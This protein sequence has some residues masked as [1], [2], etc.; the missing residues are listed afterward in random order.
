MIQRTIDILNKAKTYY[1]ADSY[2][3]DGWGLKKKVSDNYQLGF[4]PI[5]YSQLFRS[6]LFEKFDSD[7]IP[8]KFMDGEYTYL[9]TK[10]FT[11][12]LSAWHR[13]LLGYDDEDYLPIVMQ[14]ARYIEHS[15]DIGPKGAVFRNYEV[16]TGQH[17]GRVC[18]AMEQGLGI[19]IL[20]IAGEIEKDP[21]YAILAEKCLGPYFRKIEDGGVARS[22]PKYDI[23][24]WYEE[25]PTCSAHVL[26]GKLD[27]ILGPAFLHQL[28][29]SSTA[30]E[31][32]DKGLY[33]VEK[34]LP[35]FDRKYWSNYFI[36]DQGQAYIASMKYHSIHIF[37]LRALATL[38]DSAL[39]EQYAALFQRYANSRRNRLKALTV[40]ASQKVRKLHRR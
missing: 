25:F 39:C 13:Y 11:Y 14:I 2:V 24:F 9:Y 5:D 12:A 16:A 38:G 1:K 30:K 28:T 27:A 35:V 8:L 26:N 31:V 21:R 18:G 19:F 22:L 40:I 33:A 6:S 32:V 17:S 20:C 29:G 15:L 37:Q 3:R 34:M 4:Y 23:E 36:N 10:V 7:G